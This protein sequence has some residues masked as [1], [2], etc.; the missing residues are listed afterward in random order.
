MSIMIASVI[1]TTYK[2][3]LI[4]DVI[5]QSLLNQKTKYEY[6]ILVCDD[7][8]DDGSNYELV[9]KYANNQQKIGISYL[10]QQDKGFRAAAAR[11]G[12][13]RS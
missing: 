10:W 4:L 13:D 2:Q 3:A 9:K 7:G 5:L 6:E 8:T 11:N 12:R 1:I